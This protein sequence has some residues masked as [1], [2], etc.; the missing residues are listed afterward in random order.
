MDIKKFISNNKIDND[1]NK[2]IQIEI[3]AIKHKTSES[4]NHK[5]LYKVSECDFLKPKIP[6]QDMFKDP[7]IIEFIKMCQDDVV[8]ENLSYSGPMIKRRMDPNPNIDTMKLPITNYYVVTLINTKGRPKDIL[9]EEFRTDVVAKSGYYIVKTT[10]SIF[11]LDKKP[12]PNLSASIL[13]NTDNLDRIALNGDDLWVSGM[14]ILE[15]YKRVSCYDVSI[16]D[17]VFGYPEDILDIYDRSNVDKHTIKNMIDTVNTDELQKV[18]GEKIETTFI[19]VDDQKYTVLEYIL[20]KMMEENIHPVISYQMKTMILYLIKF[21]YF[22]PIFFVAKMIGFDKKYP[23]M[24]ESILDLKHRIPIDPNVDTKSLESIYHIDMWILHHLIKT[25]SEDQFVDYISRMGIVK[26]FKQ[27]SKTIEK[28][29][30][31]LIEFKAIK[32]ISTL[33]D[34]VILSDQHRYK[35][36]FLTQEFNLLGRD[37]LRR[38][39]LK[40]TE[41]NKTIDKKV[42]KDTPKNNNDK[43]H[44]TKKHGTNSKET[45]KTKKNKKDEEYSEDEISQNSQKSNASDLQSE[46]TDPDQSIDTDVDSGNEEKLDVD[47]KDKKIVENCDKQ[48]DDDQKDS[49]DQQSND[50]DKSVRQKD[51]PSHTT[52]TQI[53]QHVVQPTQIQ[54]DDMAASSHKNKP[55]ITMTTDT[56]DLY[57]TLDLHHQRMVLNI[58]PIIIDKSLTRAFYMVLK[59]CPYILESGDVK[60]LYSEIRN[61]NNKKSEKTQKFKSGGNILHTISTDSSV[62]ILEIIL[63]KNR[64]LI[65]EKDDQGRT[66]LI[67]FAELGLGKCI[68]KLIEYGADYEIVDSNSDTFLHKLC[69]NGKLDIVQNIVRNVIDIIDVKNDK[70]MTPAL[71][72][73]ANKHEEIFY[74]LKGL[75]ANLD[76]VDIYGNT[77]YHYICESRICPGILVVNK[78][79]KFGFTPYDYCKI[80]HKFYYFQK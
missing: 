62:D 17:P 49:E 45:K 28:I 21:Q 6:I 73:A 79:N 1:Y 54:H 51:T 40:R 63:K 48:S 8:L 38:Y 30:D 56:G 78:K 15:M 37:F 66:P 53:Q 16:T 80:D 39:V 25:D 76:E 5:C 41:N 57:H 70:M 77:V 64:L 44:S 68:Q 2:M 32:I 50:Q 52:T 10:N 3:E 20:V 7:N 27:D 71:L 72:A 33:I 61:G 58:L 4:N 29:V 9:K 14:F 26:K 13:S 34:C 12:S 75:N 35:I 46:S 24:Y 31:W 22:R 59:L 60:T 69:T 23:G 18:D 42:S 43:E 55:S 19:V 11:Y 67:L 47:T 74:I 65:D 36:I